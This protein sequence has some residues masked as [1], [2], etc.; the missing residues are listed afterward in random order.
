MGPII[1]FVVLIFSD[2]FGY[3]VLEILEILREILSQFNH[4]VS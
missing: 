2:R 3:M 4:I 1:F